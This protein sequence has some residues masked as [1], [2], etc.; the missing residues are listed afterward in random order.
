[1]GKRVTNVCAESN[2][3]RLRIDEALG[4][5]KSVNNQK[6]KNKSKKKKRKNKT[7]FVAI[8]DPIPGA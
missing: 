3:D 6:K 2:Y 1:M 8:R 7:T 5:L 4:I